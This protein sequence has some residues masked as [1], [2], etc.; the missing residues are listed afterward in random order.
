MSTITEK[1][2][3]CI[4]P[5]DLMYML[6]E[7]LQHIETLEAENVALAGI[8]STEDTHKTTEG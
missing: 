7:I 1:I 6:D 2:K 3:E 5:Y 4:S 8:R